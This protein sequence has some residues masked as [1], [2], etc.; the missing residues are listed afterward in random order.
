MIGRLL[1]SL[2]LGF[3]VGTT[4]LLLA[5]DLGRVA[6]PTLCGGALS[7]SPGP[8]RLHF[9]CVEQGGL[10]RLVPAEQVV[11]HTVA[12]CAAAA[13]LPVSLLFRGVEAVE[14]RRRKAMQDDMALARPAY[15]DV[16]R[17]GVGG[18]VKRQILMRAAELRLTLWVTPLGGRP[19]EAQVVWFVEQEQVGRL[20]VGAALPV[21][22]NP[23]HPERVYPAEPWAQ[24]VSW[25]QGDQM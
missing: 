25:E 2:V 14:R 3:V 6:G 10:L 1:V 9:A 22:V 23:A 21:R 15:A 18:N 4:G 24:L 16:L 12:I 5:P 13:L 19:Y 8:G 17:V 7:P 11:L 20:D